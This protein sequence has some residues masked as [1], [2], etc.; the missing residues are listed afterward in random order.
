MG[1]FIRGCKAGH[2]ITKEGGELN[3]GVMLTWQGISLEKVYGPIGGTFW[4]ER[5]FVVRGKSLTW[6]VGK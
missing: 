5:N 6:Q 2:D 4:D 1:V 3:R